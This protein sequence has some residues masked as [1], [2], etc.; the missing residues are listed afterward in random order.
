MKQ[1]R[2]D[3]VQDVE[4]AFKTL[5]SKL[6]GTLRARKKE[7][8][9]SIKSTSGPLEKIL[10]EGENH[11]TLAVQRANFVVDSAKALSEATQTHSREFQKLSS[12]LSFEASA[13]QN[14]LQADCLKW[15]SSLALLPRKKEVRFDSTTVEEAMDTLTTVIASCG[16]LIN[17]S[18]E[19]PSSSS[20][21]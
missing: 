15:A 9:D 4:S 10:Q 3:S 12:T 14:T 8:L 18:D 5:E 16:N 20:P 11:T 13:L 19:F 2:E 6:L 21:H 17:Q 1:S 7:L